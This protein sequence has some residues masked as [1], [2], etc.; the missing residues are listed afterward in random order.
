MRRFFAA[1]SVLLIMLISA[2]IIGAEDAIEYIS[3]VEIYA[4]GYICGTCAQEIKSMLMQEE[5][6]DKVTI[7]MSKGTIMII[8]KMDGGKL[9]LYSLWMKLDTSREYV[10]REM[11]VVALGHIVRFS[12]AIYEG[13]VQ[14]ASHD[15]YE[16]YAGQTEFLLFQNKQLDDLIQSGHT[17][18]SIMGTVSSFSHEVPILVIGEFG[19]PESIEEAKTHT[20]K[21]PLDMLADSLAKEKEI[22]KKNKHNHIDSARV[23]VDTDVHAKGRGQSMEESR[24]KGMLLK[25][26]GVADVSIA[27]EANLIEIIPKE[28]EMFYLYNIRRDIDAERG[29]KVVKID[30]VASGDVNEL[31]TMYPSTMDMKHRLQ[32]RKQYV[33]SAGRYTGFVLADNDKLKEL[34]NSGYKSVTV[35][36]TVTAFKAEV[37]VLSIKDFQQLLERPE[38][39]NY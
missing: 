2:T 17:S 36:G 7:N 4:D 8:P 9:N 31:G 39:L 33:L 10:T 13:D 28:D 24:L 22:M 34:L 6:V 19:E 12:T 35:V 18:V 23:Y 21:E 29:Y 30:V 20:Y 15:R 16:F 26:E 25:E 32:P 14:T 38:W 11:H 37:P 27:P 1:A 5:G 3:S